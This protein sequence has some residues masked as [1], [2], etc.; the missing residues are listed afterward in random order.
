MITK[1]IKNEASNLPTTN[2]TAYASIVRTYPVSNNTSINQFFFDKF[3]GRNL[4]RTAISF[5]IM[6]TVSATCSIWPL[7]V[8][9][10]ICSGS[11]VEKVAKMNLLVTMFDLEN[12][13][14]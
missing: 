11:P 8:P 12:Q 7:G 4:G 1:T 3:S 2:P 9:M 13:V 6:L 14:Q 10:V 5:N